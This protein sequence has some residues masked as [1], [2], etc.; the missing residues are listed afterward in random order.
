MHIWSAK[1][2]K[3]ELMDR[4]KVKFNTHFVRSVLR[5]DLGMRYRKIKKSAFLGNNARSKV[6]RLIFA[7][8]MFEVLESQARV[9]VIDE[10]AV[11]HYDYRLKKWSEPGSKANV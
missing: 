3:S 7:K 5:D 4:S 2:V 8:R 6:A 10:S 11:P 1:Q 9:I